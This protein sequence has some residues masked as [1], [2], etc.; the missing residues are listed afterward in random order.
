MEME[1]LTVEI[2]LYKEVHMQQS[3]AYNFFPLVVPCGEHSSCEHPLQ[4]VLY[5]HRLGSPCCW[6]SLGSVKPYQGKWKHKLYTGDF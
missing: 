3:L 1:N 2:C 6:T 5:V 4:E